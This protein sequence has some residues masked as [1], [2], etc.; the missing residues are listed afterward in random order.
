VTV[1]AASAVAVRLAMDG[2][3]GAKRL[4]RHAVPL[5][6]FALLSGVAC[7]GGGE[8][9]G[10][11]ISGI[12]ATVVDSATGQR[13][14]DASVTVTNAADSLVFGLTPYVSDS[15]CVY[16]EYGGAQ[17]PPSFDVHATRMGYLD[18]S[19]HA[20]STLPMISSCSDGG[21]K[22]QVHISMMKVH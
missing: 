4:L 10:D 1:L 14:C 19:V 9:G 6:G 22:I 20:V 18:A 8:C 12:Y 7:R 17:A 21:D 13:I 16:A 2:C 11:P 5:L 3:L 15:G